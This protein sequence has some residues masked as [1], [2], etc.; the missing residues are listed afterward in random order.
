MVYLLIL[1]IAALLA[2]VAVSITGFL[3]IKEAINKIMEDFR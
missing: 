3:L 2:V 1:A